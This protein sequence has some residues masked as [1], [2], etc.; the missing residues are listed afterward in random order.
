MDGYKAVACCYIITNTVNG[1]KYIGQTFKNI[2]E[3]F[4]GFPYSHNVDIQ[5]DVRTFGFAS[6]EVEILP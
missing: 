5:K 2:N 6:F 3:R 4:K 1:K